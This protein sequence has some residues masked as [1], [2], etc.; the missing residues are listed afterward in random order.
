MQS[1]RIVLH[2]PKDI[3]DHPIICNSPGSS[4]STSACSA[5]D[6]KG[7]RRHD[8][9]GPWARTRTSAPRAPLPD[10][11][12]RPDRAAPPG[13]PHHPEEM[14]RLRRPASRNARPTP[15]IPS[16]RRVEARF[17]EM[18]RLPGLRPGVSLRGHL[19]G[20]RVRSLSISSTA[21][22]ESIRRA[23]ARARGKARM[24][25]EVNVLNGASTVSL[26]NHVNDG[27]AHLLNRE[28][29]IVLFNPAAE[30]IMH[31]KAEDALG[32]TCHTPLHRLRVRRRVRDDRTPPLHRPRRL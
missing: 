26:L 28:R 14:R 29:R 16:T 20:I 11:A 5:A 31:V 4:P 27:V 7:H 1:H 21:S 18:R 19:R 32:K 3:V 15:S 30:R 9:A 6:R 17:G 25:N 23:T 24:S 10:R 22:T 13:H 2:F 8:G 12:G